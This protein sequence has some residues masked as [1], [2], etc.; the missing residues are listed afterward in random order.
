MKSPDHETHS[1]RSSLQPE[2]VAL[3]KRLNRI[4]G[5]VRGISK[6]IE[7]ERYCVDILTQVSAIRSALDETA[8]RLLEDHTKGCVRKAIHSGEGEEA[9]AEL[10]DVTRKY[11]RS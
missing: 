7:E 8:L 2:K 11:L 9:I 6:M 10:T 1:R 3:I 4:E 5:Q